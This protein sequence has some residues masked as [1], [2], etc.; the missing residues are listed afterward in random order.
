MCWKNFALSLCAVFAFLAAVRAE[1]PKFAQLT[2]KKLITAPAPDLKGGVIFSAGA[3]DLSA[4][5]VVMIFADLKSPEG[6]RFVHAP[7]TYKGEYTDPNT[8]IAG[9][10]YYVKDDTYERY[11]LISRDDISGNALHH[12]W[13]V[14]FN[15]EGVP[16]AY[17]QG[18]FGSKP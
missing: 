8:K 9:H 17:F 2:T 15:V 5:P 1:D 3:F 12:R 14:D 13:V 6:V 7:I 11:F 10:L 16:L 4:K 18:A